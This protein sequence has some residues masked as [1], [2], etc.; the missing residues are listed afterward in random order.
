MHKKT[1]L[2]FAVALVILTTTTINALASDCWT[3]VWQ[4]CTGTIAS[5][6]VVQWK[7][8]I[9]IYDVTINSSNGHRADCETVSQGGK[10]GH[11]YHQVPCRVN[12]HYNDENAIG[13]EIDYTSGYVNGCT[14]YGSIC[15]A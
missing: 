11:D 6:T 10:I 8:G 12:A 13:H 7:D 1:T 5:G 4:D 3:L 15:G 14:P 9:N 2:R